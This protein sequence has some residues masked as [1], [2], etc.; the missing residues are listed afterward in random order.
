[1]TTKAA[2]LWLAR[3]KSRAPSRLP[4][5]WSRFTTTERKIVLMLA[6]METHFAAYPFTGLS[7]AQVELMMQGIRAAASLGEECRFA[8]SYTRDPP[9]V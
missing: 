9:K 5:A 2:E 4:V 7:N 8:L 6:G 3:N 1:M